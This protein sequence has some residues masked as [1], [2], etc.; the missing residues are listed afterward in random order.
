MAI[1]FYLLGWLLIA[2]GVLWNVFET[3]VFVQLGR[4]GALVPV[5]V[6]GAYVMLAGALFLAIGAIIRRLDRIVE[7]S[8]PWDEAEE[9]EEEREAA[10][11]QPLADIEPPLTRQ[12]R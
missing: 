3:I 9:F 6:A 5:L 4:A 10:L 1:A 12:S 7:N 2:A 8:A 11:R